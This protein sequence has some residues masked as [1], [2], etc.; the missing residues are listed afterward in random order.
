[1]SSFATFWTQ[2]PALLYGLAF[3]FGISL[4]LEHFWILVPMIIMGITLIQCPYRLALFSLVIVS[5]ICFFQ[6]TTKLPPD[7]PIEGTAQIRLSSVKPYH[8]AFRK[9]SI[10]QGT[11]VSFVPRNS[12]KPI[13]QNIPFSLKTGPSC[14]KANCD[15]IIRATLRHRN[16]LFPK[17]GVPWQSVPNTWSLAEWRFQN[18]QALRHFIDKQMAHPKAASFLSGMATGLFDDN[19]LYSELSRFGLQH[20]M[21]ISGFHFALVALILSFGLNCFLPE[22]KA[23]IA[24]VALMTLYFIFLGASPSILRAWIM[25]TV[26]FLGKILE[27]QSK[28]LNSLGAA[29]IVVLVIDPLTLTTIGFQFSF[30]VT[31]SILLFTAPIESSLRIVLKKRPLSELIHMNLINQHGYLAVNALRQILALTLSV[32][33]VVIPLALYW[34]QKFPVM[35][36]LY[37]TFFPFLASLSLV[38]LLIGLGAPFAGFIHTINSYFTDWMLNLAYR[39]PM[40]LDIWIRVQEIP[41]S[42]LV[43][44]LCG[45]FAGGIYIKIIYSE[46][47][48]ERSELAYL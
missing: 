29:L 25:A 21:A 48:R 24:L 45:L 20:I 5:A 7:E 33:I 12:S 44:Y 14:P 17:K 23:S 19:T 1:M 4:A 34:F 8:T 36:L 38:L 2:H 3:A 46:A 18:K 31:S 16:Y 35:S 22:K 41:L 9:G 37:N 43:V 26:Y 27:K 30:L 39:L 28:A 6:L 40:S 15:Y 10:I 13:A 32:Q 47:Q 42:L 11:L